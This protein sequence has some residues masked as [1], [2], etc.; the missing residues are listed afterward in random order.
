MSDFVLFIFLFFKVPLVLQNMFED[1][2]ILL[3][4]LTLDFIFVYTQFK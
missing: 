2:S 1:V 4:N 3:L